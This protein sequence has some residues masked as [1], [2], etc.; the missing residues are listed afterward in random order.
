MYAVPYHVE[1]LLGMRIGINGGAIKIACYVCKV[2]VITIP[3]T[4]GLVA[5][6]AVARVMLPTK[7]N[8]S[9]IKFLRKATGLSAKD[10]AK[11]ISVRPET[12]SRW[13]NSSEQQI[14]YSEE[15]IFRILV[16]D[17]LK[18]EPH[19]EGHA[20]AIDYDHMTII[21]MIINPIR[22]SGN[23]PLLK[24]ERVNMKVENKKP[25]ELWDESRPKV[26]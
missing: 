9:E 7:L 10:F 1:N 18:N 2:E 20:L 19:G 3:D 14:G 11:T 13:E 5:A 23:S 26:A 6:A 21:K 12:L 24:F 15:K 25:Q 4:K 16:G 22:P 8:G 17:K